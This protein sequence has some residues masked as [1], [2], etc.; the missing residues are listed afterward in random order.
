MLKA[1]RVEF[2]NVCFSYDGK[3]EILEDLTFCAT[4]GQTIALVGETGGGKST[5]LKLLFRFYDVN[6]GSVIIDGQD[7]RDV[8]LE[9]LRE[10]VGVVPQQPVLFND[11]IMSNVRYSKFDATDD[12]VMEACKAAAVHN[13]IMSFTNGYLSK[14]GERGIKLSG[15]EMQR[16]AIARA[17]LMDPKIVLLDEATSSVDVET[18]MEIQ[19]AFKTLTAGRTTFV[20]AHNLSTVMDADITMVIGNGTI[21]E[22]GS[23]KQLLKAKGRYFE[24]WSKQMGIKQN[25]M[26]S[27]PIA[28]ESSRSNSTVNHCSEDLLGDYPVE[29]GTGLISSLNLDTNQPYQGFFESSGKGKKIWKPDAPEFVPKSLRGSP[30]EIQPPHQHHGTG[31]GQTRGEAL[32]DSKGDQEKKKR[33]RRRK[34]EDEPPICTTGT[35][36]EIITNVKTGDQPNAPKSTN[37][38]A[39]KGTE[40]KA[41]KNRFNRRKQS[42]SEPAGSGLDRSQRDGSSEVKSTPDGSG[43]GLSNRND[44]RRVSASNEQSSVPASLRAS[45]YGQRRRRRGHWKVKNRDS[46]NPSGIQSTGAST[47]WST[48]TSVTPAAP[49]ASPSNGINAESELEKSNSGNGVRFAPGF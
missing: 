26:D 21:L 36:G 4:P 30:T 1:G 27:E 39:L 23:P 25:I 28:S 19:K 17:I 2:N 48:D 29:G 13:K 5:I 40:L 14:V 33:G 38:E 22:R 41:K 6:T 10:C 3:K 15:G 20:V 31:F 46:S 24:L 35:L 16:I 43:E 44:S 18:E 8:T 45:T 11:T 32:S 9:S 34:G 7:V 37:E 47:N 12:E 42:R 49:C